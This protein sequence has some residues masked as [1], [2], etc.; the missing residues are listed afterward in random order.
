[1]IQDENIYVVIKNECQR[2]DFKAC[3]IHS[4]LGWLT[5]PKVKKLLFSTEI[6]VPYKKLC[7]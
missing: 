3:V 5:V 7:N 1:M 6:L 4:S 2:Y